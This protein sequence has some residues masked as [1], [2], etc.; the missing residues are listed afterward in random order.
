MTYVKGVD[1]SIYQR[2]V[3]WAQLRV[4]GFQFFY[5]RACDGS[6]VDPTHDGHIAAGRAAGLLGGSY[7]FGHP[8]MPVE[9]LVATFLAKASIVPGQLRPVIDMETLSEGHVPENAGE[10]ADR[11][12]E[13]VKEQTGTE[14]II[15]ASTSYWTTMNHLRPS[16]GGPMGWDWW[17]AQYSINPPTSWPWVAWQNFGDVTLSGQVGKWDLDVTRD[18]DALRV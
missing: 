1:V 11:W 13:L 6:S 17:A 16:V 15:Y 12:C 14:P 5:A 7:Q 8:S 10:W 9:A 2:N 3:D 4:D 18:L